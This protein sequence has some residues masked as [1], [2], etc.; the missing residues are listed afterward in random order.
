MEDFLRKIAQLS[1]YPG[2]PAGVYCSSQLHLQPNKKEQS[3]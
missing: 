1:L 3:K 2:V